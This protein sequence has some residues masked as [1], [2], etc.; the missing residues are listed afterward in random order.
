MPSNGRSWSGC[1]RAASTHPRFP[2]LLIPQP[3]NAR[4]RDTV[5]V[6][7]HDVVVGYLHQTTAQAFLAALRTNEF[8]RGVCAAMLIVRQEP[9]LGDQ[10]F[11]VRLDALVP[12]KLA[13]AANQ[14]PGS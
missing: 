11:R 1:A 10:A 4:G 3:T 8:D 13:D 14:A 12:F 9:Q 2:A 5:A 7:I 6:R